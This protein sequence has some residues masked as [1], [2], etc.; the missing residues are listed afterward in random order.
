MQHRLGSCGM[1]APFKCLKRS[2]RQAIPVARTFSAIIPKQHFS[3]ANSSI[4]IKAFSCRASD[5]LTS[6][7]TSP[8]LHFTSFSTWCSVPPHRD[9]NRMVNSTI[10]VGFTPEI[11]VAAAYADVMAQMDGLTFT[12]NLLNPGLVSNPFVLCTQSRSA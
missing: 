4:R 3:S 10:S 8:T 7:A 11:Y 5:L 9:R 1:L 6:T 12:N 2:H